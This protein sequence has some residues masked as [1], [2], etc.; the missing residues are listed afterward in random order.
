[1]APLFVFNEFENYLI[2]EKRFSEHT[3]V[4]YKNDL[5]QFLSYYPITTLEQLEELNYQI[6]RSWIVQLMESKVSNRT[7][8]RKLSTLRSFCKWAQRSSY[9]SNNPMQKIVAP[10]TEKRLPNFIKQSELSSEKTFDFFDASYNGKRNKLIVEL[11]GHTD[12]TGDMCKNLALSEKRAKN[13]RKSLI[14]AGVP[15]A[16]IVI[17]G[18]GSA[19][20]KANNETEENRAKN[21]RVSFIFK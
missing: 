20:P 4:A 19:Q 18:F 11:E 8:N 15:E 12:K 21:R 6:I 16:R 10:K 2:T 13:V 17:K 1:M 14:K 7:V 5:F 3:L 9:L